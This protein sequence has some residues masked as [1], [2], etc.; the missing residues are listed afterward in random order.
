[1][2]AAKER[3]DRDDSWQG[4]DAMPR[5]SKFKEDFKSKRCAEIKVVLLIFANWLRTALLVTWA[6][7]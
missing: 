3:A 7:S 1:V 2:F 6:R 5:Y 4:L